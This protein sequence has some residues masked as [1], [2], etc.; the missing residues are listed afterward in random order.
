[1]DYVE[2]EELSSAQKVKL[3]RLY[4]TRKRFNDYWTA[5]LAKVRRGAD[6]DQVYTGTLPN[7]VILFQ[8]Q[9][10][11]PIVNLGL[12]LISDEALRDNSL[13]S[14]DRFIQIIKTAVAR[15]NIDPPRYYTCRPMGYVPNRLG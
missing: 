7:P 6:C 12:P 8:E 10:Q 11:V 1:M 13:E 2:D 3:R 4:F 15:A 14:T 9:F 5:L